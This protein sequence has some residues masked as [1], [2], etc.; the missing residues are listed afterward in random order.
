MGLAG[1]LVDRGREWARGWSATAARRPSRFLARCSRTVNA[2]GEQPTT[3]AASVAD[4][5]CQVTR[6]SVSTS[7]AGSVASASSAAA[8]STTCSPASHASRS[9]SVVS[10][11]MCVGEPPLPAGLPELL[12]QQ[13][14][15]HAEQPWQRR[16]GNVG[17]PPPRDQERLARHVLGGPLVRMLQGVPQD[18]PVVLVVQPSESLARD[19]SRG[20]LPVLDRHQVIHREARNHTKI[21]RLNCRLLGARARP[22]A[23]SRY[24]EADGD[25]LTCRRA[26]R[27]LGDETNTAV[28]GK[29]GFGEHPCDGQVKDG[30][31]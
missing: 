9:A 22:S 28:T 8:R 23:A 10:A 20:L 26:N 6:V 1:N 5:P 31:R 11:E 7:S 2:R 4:R 14:P 30:A 24:L 27:I 13:V 18:P 15:R 29:D 19:R 12:A 3:A 21:E 16:L 25:P 17:Q